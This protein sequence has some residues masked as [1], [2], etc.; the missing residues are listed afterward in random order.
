MGKI[1]LNQTVV[2]FSDEDKTGVQEVDITSA[3]EL[4]TW[5][6]ISHCGT[7]LN[8]SLENWN[9]LVELADKAKSQL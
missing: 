4:G 7:E 8:M 9:K 5:I 2:L 6:T 1:S 3:D